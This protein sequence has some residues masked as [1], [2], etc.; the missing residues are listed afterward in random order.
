V[1]P[2]P[3]RYTRNFVVRL[4][5]SLLAL[6]LGLAA[7][8]R[9]PGT[10]APPPQRAESPGRDPGELGNFIQ[11]DDPYADEYIVHDISPEHSRWRWAFQRPELR[12]RPRKV[13]S[14]KFALEF[15]IPEVTFRETGPIIVTCIVNDRPLGSIR[16][17]RAGQYRFE[18]PVPDGLLRPGEPVTVIALADKRFTAKEDGAQLSFLLGSAG[19]TE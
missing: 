13:H 19:F 8:G 18:K 17:P 1:W 10:F 16:C 5:P 11:M 7:C 9:Q 3:P 4:P 6:S 2:V 12:F 15:A 14:L